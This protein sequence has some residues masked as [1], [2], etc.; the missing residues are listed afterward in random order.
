MQRYGMFDFALSSN[1]NKLHI[2]FKQVDIFGSGFKT[3]LEGE[4]GEGSYYKPPPIVVF[5]TFLKE[6]SILNNFN[7]RICFTFF[8]KGFKFTDF[9]VNIVNDINKSFYL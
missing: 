5:D 9:V 4:G 6:I 8:C 3:P 2:S 1:L 7:G